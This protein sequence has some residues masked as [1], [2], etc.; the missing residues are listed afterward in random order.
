MGI[1]DDTLLQMTLSAGALHIR[2]VRVRTSEEGSPWLQELYDDFAPVR[3]EAQWSDYTDEEINQ[4]IDDGI[5]AAR[6]Q[7]RDESGS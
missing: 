7:Q 1:T 5:A 6:Q 3:D 4:W 2:P